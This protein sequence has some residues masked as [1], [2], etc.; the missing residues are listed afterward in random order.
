MQT[1]E[2]YFPNDILPGLAD[3]QLTNQLIVLDKEC[4]EGITDEDE[5]TLDDW[6]SVRNACTGAVIY[7]NNTPVG[8]IDFVAL[9]Q[10]GIELMRQGKVQDGKLTSLT[11]EIKNTGEMSLYLVCI[12]LKPAFRGKGLGNLLWN[13][14]R[15]G[16]IEKKVKVKEVF[17]TIWTSE[18][19]RFLNQFGLEDVAQDAKNHRIVRLLGV[20]GGVL[21]E[22]GVYRE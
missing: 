17:A 21:P 7:S 4:F 2:F 5:G 8:Y 12:A 6:L 11:R 10:Q 18:G 22:A 16:L 9:N 19:D 20:K 13:T 1:L 14:T 15:N 3:E